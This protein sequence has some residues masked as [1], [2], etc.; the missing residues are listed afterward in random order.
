[1]VFGWPVTW[2]Q[3]R[4]RVARFVTGVG[5]RFVRT[6]RFRIG[7][8]RAAWWGVVGLV[9]RF[10]VGMVARAA[11]WAGSGYIWCICEDEN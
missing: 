5:F 10:R 11:W 4:F 1:M 7:F 2:S 6:T 3:I 8:I 9:F